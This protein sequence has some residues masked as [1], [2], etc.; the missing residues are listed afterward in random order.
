MTTRW[1]QVHVLFGT[2]ALFMAAA[3][4]ALAQSTAEIPLG[5][6]IPSASVQLDRVDGG[7]A[8]LG[9]LQGSVGTV[10]VF[11]SNQ[12][13]WVEKY[14]NRL[15]DAVNTYSGQG[16]GFVLINSNNPS[17]YPQET[18]AQSAQRA[19]S[20]NYPSGLAYLADPSSDVARAFGAERT[21]HVF[22]FDENGTLVY[23][24]AVD[25]SPGDEGNVTDRYLQQA[26]DAVVGGSSVPVPQTKAFGCT[27]KYTN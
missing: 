11:W 2:A 9:S 8:S 10:V 23:V 4:P 15:I 18:A 27:I 17:A 13:P 24:G 12:C 21:P 7:Q 22:L 20:G 6:E 3:L 25:D 16:I 26:L 5:S 1:T 14:E 19:N